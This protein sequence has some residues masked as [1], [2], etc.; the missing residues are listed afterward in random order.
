MLSRPPASLAAAIRLAPDPVERAAGQQQPLDL[1]LGHHRGEAVR[2]DEEHVARTGGEDVRVDLHARLRPERA[3]DHGALW[4]RLGLL[5]GQLAARDELTH[6]RVVAREADQVAAAQQVAARVA[7]VGDDDRVLRHVR[8][9]E[10]RPH[11]RALAVGPR[12][13]VDARVRGLDR[14]DEPLARVAVGQAALERADR[15]RRRHLAGLRAAHPVRHDEQ[16][17]AHEIVVLVALALAAQVGVVEVLGD[18]QHGSA[19]ERELRVADADP[20]THVQRL[21][22]PAAA[23]H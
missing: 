13:L 22:D 5:L 18:P 19:L 15:H 14:L 10:R 16:R 6:Q 4:M 1:R 20:V 3:R 21:R 23:R 11:A 12:A 7:H 17:R 2:A 9:G 8:G